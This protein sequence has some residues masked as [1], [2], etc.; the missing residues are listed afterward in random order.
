MRVADEGE[1]ALIARLRRMIEG[2][3]QGLICGAGDDTAV[4]SSE[5][6]GA[7][8]YT[9]DAMV[10]GVHFD[11]AYTPWHSLGFKSLAVNIS[12]LAAMG[13]SAPSF[14]LVVLG[15]SGDTEVEAVEE[16]YRGMDEC[17]RQY[18]CNVVGGD[19]V[20][21]PQQ[22]FI[23]VSLVGP[24]P[25][26]RFL[27]RGGARPGQAVIVTGTLGDSFLG[28]KWLM[29]GGSD[30][31][32]CAQ[33]HLYP[34]PRLREGS[35]ALES[36]ASACIDISDGL[37]LDLGHICEE[38]GVGAEIVMDDI[39]ISVAAREMARELGEDA[40]GAALYGG[41]DYEIIVVI[42]EDK[43][44]PLRQ[45]L[46]LSVIG[47]ITEGEGVV[48]LDPSGRRVDGHRSGYEHFK[49]G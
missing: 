35:R 34:L 2:E 48:V 17:G 41:E 16:M 30:S 46:G 7:W 47:R 10:E 32:P 11:P 6:S 15:L 39:P 25:G 14:A 20:R 24:V 26:G 29:G 37:L 1:F 9:A 33:R 44:S 21:S 12:D 49:E 8:A 28:L 22:V 42:D 36:G 40:A 5:A 27:T 31:N 3:R 43:V 4:F 19:I 13:G 18:G 38:S 45:E 23:S